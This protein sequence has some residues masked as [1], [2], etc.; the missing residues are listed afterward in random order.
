MTAY[1]AR[2]ARKLFDSIHFASV[3]LSH[4]N[5]VLRLTGAGFRRSLKSNL[6]VSFHSA[7][8]DLFNL[9]QVLRLT[10]TFNNL[11]QGELRSAFHHGLFVVVPSYRASFQKNKECCESSGS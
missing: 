3:I 7:A 1:A 9:I 8:V 2:A 11:Q 5:Q 10:R 4:L 6:F